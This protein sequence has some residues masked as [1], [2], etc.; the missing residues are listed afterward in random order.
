MTSLIACETPSYLSYIYSVFLP[1]AGFP[2]VLLYSENS[3]GEQ[4]I[5]LTS[6]SGPCNLKGSLSSAVHGLVYILGSVIV[7]V[8][9][10]GVVVR[11]VK[12]LL[13]AQI[14]TVWTPSPVDPG[15]FVGTRRL[16]DKRVIVHPFTD[17]ISEPSRFRILGQISAVRPDR[18]PNFPK[19]V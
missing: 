6:N 4:I 5:S 13:D 8:S 16:Y 11:A 10:Q 17:R 19:F 3:E 18:A 15:P 12:S 9:S 1:L 2:T 14:G 7:T